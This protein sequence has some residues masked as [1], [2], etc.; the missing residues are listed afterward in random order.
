MYVQKRVMYSCQ[1][2]ILDVPKLSSY[3]CRHAGQCEEMLLQVL[4]AKRML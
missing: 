2:N 1:G 3:R 4:I